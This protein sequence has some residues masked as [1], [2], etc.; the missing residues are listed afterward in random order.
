MLP[1][2]PIPSKAALRVLRSI[3]LGTSCLIG[4]VVEDRRRRISTLKIAVKNKKQLQSSRQYRRNSLEDLS[5][6]LGGEVVPEHNIQ[7]YEKEE[8]GPGKHYDTETIH[9]AA[10]GDP[11]VAESELPHCLDEKNDLDPV[12]GPQPSASQSQSQLQSQSQ[13]SPSPPVTSRHPSLRTKRQ[14]QPFLATDLTNN[15][16]FTRA[17][18]TRQPALSATLQQ[19]EDDLIHSIEDLLGSIDEGR[20]ERAVKLF[21]SGRPPTPSSPLL[22]KWLDI[23]IRISRECQA[24]GMWEHAS[25]IL[26]SIISL[27]PLDETRYLAHNPIPTVEYHLR[28]RDPDIPQSAGQ[29]TL[30]AKLFLAT[31]ETVPKTRGVHMED[32]GKSLIVQSLSLRLFNLPQMVFWRTLGWSPNPVEF[33]SWAIHTFFQHRDYKAVVKIF[34]LYYSRMRPGHER[35]DQTMDYVME[36]VLATKGLDADKILKAFAQMHCPGNGKLR[37]RWVMRLLQAHWARYEDIS[38]TI[39]LFDKAVLLGLLDKVGHPQGVYRTLVDMAVKAGDEKVAYT[40]ADELIRDYPDMKN[41][42]ALKLAV[43]RAKAGDW[44]SVLQAF[45]QVRPNDLAE[46]ALYTDA[47]ILILKVFTDSHSAAETQGFVMLFI[48][49]MGISFHRHMVTLVAKKYAEDRDMKGFVRW[50]ELCSREGFAFDAGFCNSVL[51]NCSRIWKLSF[52]ELRKI[53]SHFKTINP[54]CSDEVTQ[55]ILNQ[56][57]HREGKRYRIDRKWKVTLSN[58]NNRLAYRGRSTNSRE[59]YEVMNHELTNNKPSSAVMIYRRAR[60]FGMPFSSHCFRLVVLALLR[61]KGYGPDFALSLLQHAHTKGHDVESAVTIFIRHEIDRFIGN[62]QDVII[63]MRNLLGQLESLQIPIGL[64]VLTH[65]ANACVRVGQH[66]KAI[67]LCNIARDRGGESHPFLSKQSFKVLA[68]AYSNLLDVEGMNSLM[69]Y[70]F[71]SEFSTD[72]VLLSHF[73]SIRRLVE[74]KDPSLSRTV[75]LDILD[76]G[77]LQLTRSRAKARTEGRLISYETLRIMGDALADLRGDNTDEATPPAP[78][79]TSEKWNHSIKREI[80]TEG[81]VRLIAA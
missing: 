63:H 3:A 14:V 33:L 10:L 79:S 78:E 72:K 59:V 56:A 29:V 40:Y 19:N 24:S 17:I 36:S 28:R 4:A 21:I 81:P 70:L 6:Q 18:S 49:E 41:D 43:F 5:W 50:L 7:W 27:G 22:E 80:V 55:R 23:S 37:T 54:H 68:S 48:Q 53:H 75:M 31:F 16:P 8:Y 44:D 2:L 25:Q 1:P 76:R 69:Y 38:H 30:A 9:Y 47:F 15:V 13:S 42:I 64:A 52:P 60:R 62:A 77:V 35:F 61:A 45:R 74:K 46:P 67:I 66:E 65:M 20:L 73:K 51:H 34:L 12:Q 57:A 26:T 11:A 71:K 58:T 39:N 32:V